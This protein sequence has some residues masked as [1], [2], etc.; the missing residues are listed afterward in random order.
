MRSY[1]TEVGLLAIWDSASMSY[2]T[3]KDD[4]L[5][6]ISDSIGLVKIMNKGKI[7]AWHTGGDGIFDIEVRQNPET[8]LTSEEKGIVELK[9]ENLKLIITS[10][11]MIGSPEWAGSPEE[12]GLK[13]NAISQIEGIN[14]GTYAVS[15]FFLYSEEVQVAKFV[16]VIKKVDPDFQFQEVFSIPSLG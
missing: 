8:S 9:N 12:D 10:K 3:T 5:A 4:Y 6:N 2:V 11:V 16:V 1:N 14:Q 15:V 13:E 7:V